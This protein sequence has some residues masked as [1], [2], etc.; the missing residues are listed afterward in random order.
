MGFGMAV[1]G[2]GLSAPL[3]LGVIIRALDSFIL[4]VKLYDLGVPFFQVT[5]I[6]LL[7]LVI[8]IAF[9][10]ARRPGVGVLLSSTLLGLTIYY[11]DHSIERPSI[12]C[13]DGQRCNVLVTGANSGIG[14]GVTSALLSQGHDVTLG[15]RSDAKCNAAWRSLPESQQEHAKTVAGL[16]LNSL[17]AT[18]DWVSR[19]V[20]TGGEKKYDIVVVNAGWTPMGNRTTEDGYEAGLGAMHFG[21]HMIVEAL[22]DAD[23][24]ATDAFIAVVSSD[25]MRLGAFD[26]SLFDENGEGDLRGEITYGC[27]FVGVMCPRK[28]AKPVSSKFITR[29]LNFGSYARAKLANV[30]YAREIP[31]RYPGL[32][33][34]AVHP[35]MVMT[36]LAKTQAANFYLNTDLGQLFNAVQDTY[37]NFV[38]RPAEVS[39]TVVLLSIQAV[40]DDNSKN[41][42]FANG[43]GQV[44]PD[45]YL[46]DPATNDAIAARLWEVTTHHVR[47]SLKKL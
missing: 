21:H 46:P 6:A 10:A 9:V 15:C 43:L 42:G 22:R 29:V 31:R 41:G 30:M 27:S 3:L 1:A 35:G 13:G 36:P 28:A 14:F 34:V 7:A 38:L 17:R 8:K 47:T 4:E 25:A 33:S 20:S 37:M 18:R 45:A 12:R 44:L 24:L 11:A 39:A 32:R 40:L 26:E 2:F 23:S 5:A 19:I 16:E